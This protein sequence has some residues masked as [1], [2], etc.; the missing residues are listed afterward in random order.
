MFLLIFLALFLTAENIVGERIK[1]FTPVEYPG[2]WHKYISRL[3]W[4]K[5][6]YFVEDGVSPQVSIT[7]DDKNTILG[8]I[9]KVLADDTFF[10][11]ILTNNGFSVRFLQEETKIVSD[12][13][14]LGS[15][16]VDY[17]KLITVGRAFSPHKNNAK[18]SE[19][20]EIMLENDC[21]LFV[22]CHSSFIF[23]WIDWRPNPRKF[24]CSNNGWNLIQQS[25]VIRP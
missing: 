18:S 15:I 8:R 25:K 4:V 9:C 23:S 22:S 1:C 10:A 13:T 17:L 14:H 21:I 24:L 3:C 6:T 16:E 20:C 7:L 2:G 11:R 5:N 19:I 12:G